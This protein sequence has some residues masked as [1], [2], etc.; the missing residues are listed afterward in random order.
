M[1]YVPHH[2]KNTN[3][4]ILAV[5]VS[6]SIVRTTG[7]WRPVVGGRCNQQKQKWQKKEGKREKEILDTFSAFASFSRL[8]LYITVNY[9]SYYCTVGHHYSM[10]TTPNTNISFSSQKFLFSQGNNQTTNRQPTNQPT[11]HESIHNN[12]SHCQ[13][14]I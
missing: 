14:C 6:S 12:R 11:N 4:G 5:V 9:S 7:M 3:K 13:S 2:N 8:Y 1:Y 10:T